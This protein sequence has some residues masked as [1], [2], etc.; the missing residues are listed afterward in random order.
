MV[1]I[2]TVPCIDVVSAGPL[3]HARVWEDQEAAYG[4]GKMGEVEKAEEP[5]WVQLDLVSE[6]GTQVGSGYVRVT[7]ALSIATLASAIV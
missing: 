4:A 6:C 5:F 3:R 2:G 7:L 1:G